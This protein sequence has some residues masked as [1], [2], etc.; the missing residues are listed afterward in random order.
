MALITS[1]KQIPAHRHLRERQH[2]LWM[3]LMMRVLG[4]LWSYR[5]SVPW[6][7]HRYVTAGGRG[8]DVGGWQDLC[9]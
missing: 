8:V 2:S 4:F 9:T 7:G 6:V 3:I 5:R 1:S